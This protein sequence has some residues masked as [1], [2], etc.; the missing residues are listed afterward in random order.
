MRTYIVD[1][2][3]PIFDSQYNGNTYAARSSN[4]YVAVSDI[5]PKATTVVDVARGDTYITS[6]QSLYS[7]D[8][9]NASEVDVTY[10]NLTL[11]IPLESSINC[12]YDLQ[13][14][15][16]YN[17]A[18]GARNSAGLGAT[19]EYGLA[20]T[21]EKGIV[22]WPDTY[23]STLEDYYR[24]NTGY[25]AQE[26]Y[27]QYFPKPQTFVD[28]EYNGTLVIASEPKTNGELVD[29]WTEFKYA[30]II[31]VD[32]AYGDVNTLETVDNKLFFWQ[33]KAFGLLAVKDR[34]LIQDGSVGQLSLGSGDVLERYDYVSTE[35]GNL[36]KYNV[37]KSEIALFWVFTPKSR[38]YIF[39]NG[40]KELS[41]SV[42][43]NKYLED[44]GGIVNPI[45]ITDFKSNETL[46][47]VNNEVLVFDWLSGAFTG[48]YTFVPEWFVRRYDGNYDSSADSNDFY[49]HNSDSVARATF[50]GTTYDS[51]IKSICNAEYNST[52]V[53]DNLEW[54]STSVNSSDV[55]QYED[56]FDEYRIT[57]DYQNTDW[58]NITWQRDERSFRTIVPRDVVDTTEVSNG[59]IFTNLDPNQTFKKRIRDKYM[60]LELK[61]DNTSNN[62]FSIPYILV[63]Y[64]RSSR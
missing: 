11:S 62:I 24:Y 17:I 22:L 59:D 33:D 45:C 38:V 54:N 12:V 50:Y 2:I 57:T 16:Y 64:R 43:I 49:S 37:T 10:K 35:V 55:N 36:E 61:Y 56:T 52:K 46:F 51:Y 27:K 28:Q 4:S 53:F 1:A 31:E 21:V 25:S 23:P 63:Y 34:S 42:S 8:D 40:L 41:T 14:A 30:N 32:T 3:N 15:S 18:R 19:V 5:I 13:A 29:S 39:D 9:P 58:Q 20:E 7:Y 60:N 48:I 26:E 6:F 47:K 44:K